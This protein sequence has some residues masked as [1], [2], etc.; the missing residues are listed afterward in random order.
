MNDFLNTEQDFSDSH[1]WIINRLLHASLLP[2]N[3]PPKSL[4]FL[5]DISLYLSNVN[6]NVP[7]C[8]S[9]SLASHLHL[10]QLELLEVSL[11]QLP[12]DYQ[13]STS[14]QW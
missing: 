8:T 3:K 12:K 2:S 9:H 5:F 11:L 1:T 7:G 14:H 4:V 13:Y 10:P 6:S